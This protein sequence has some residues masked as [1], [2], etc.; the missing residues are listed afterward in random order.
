MKFKSCLSLFSF[1]FSFFLVQAQ[2]V[3]ETQKIIITKI[4]ATWCPNCGLA[5]WDHFEELNEMFKTTA[6]L[7]NI[8]PSR[9]SAL[10]A[11]EAIVFSENLPQA[12]GQ[13]LF[14]INRTKYA[15]SQ[16][17]RA[18][19][20]AI[21]DMESVKPVANTGIRASFNEN[22]LKV[23]ARTLFFQP[24]QGAYYLSLFVVENDVI[25]SQSSRGANAIHKKVL[26]QAISPSTFGDLLHNGTIDQNASFSVEHTIEIADDW[27]RENLEIAALIWK[28]TENVFEFVNAHSQ[29]PSFSTRTNELEMPGVQLSVTP[30]IIQ[31]SGTIYLDLPK[32]LEEIQIEVFNISGQLVF[33]LFSGNLTPGKHI[34]ELN[35]SK[36]AESG[37]FILKISQ[38]GSTISRKF[39][40][41]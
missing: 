33:P 20:D 32:A 27:N 29:S 5:A 40:T 12:W 4:G 37:I 6:V 22:E 18:A 36:L 34:F 26:R 9:S 2:E 11:P 38:G 3:P 7:L 28:K 23:T 10:H 21:M 1:F 31:E 17:M 14:Y 25:A 35:R 8:H 41:K 24:A 13:P 19:A 30:T 15:T 16:I 39:V